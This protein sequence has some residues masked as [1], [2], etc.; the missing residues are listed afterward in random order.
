MP[1]HTNRMDATLEGDR[2]AER[3][4]TPRRPTDAELSG[5]S[6]M[7]LLSWFART[8][9]DPAEFRLQASFV[10]FDA[11]AM[12]RLRPSR[13]VLD[14]TTENITAVS[15]GSVFYVVCSGSVVFS[16]HG[17]D[18]TLGEGAS[19]LV[20][21]TAAHQ[22]RI[23]DGAELLLVVVRKG[24]LHGRGV[25]EPTELRPIPDTAFATAVSL[26]LRTLASDLPLPSSAEGIASQSAIVQ[27]LT[28]LIMEIA[29]MPAS[30]AQHV[31]WIASAVTFIAGNYSNPNLTT[32]AVAAATGISSRHLQRIFALA[33]TSVA[34]E[35]RRTRTRW[36]VTWIEESAGSRKLEEIAILAG[37]GTVA[38]MRRAFRRQVGMSPL[39]YRAAAARGDAPE[40]AGAGA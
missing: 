34:D 27:L 1:S 39:Q 11:L 3:I 9:A 40:P 21:G 17:K 13:S 6:G 16:Q 31:A 38:R 14:R 7:D 36:A 35:L 18:T 12:F 37:F 15:L 19:A 8:V 5:K 29:E 4:F 30:S 28:G 22:L 10:V 24:V 23:A 26:F 32:A 20:S 25:A 2:A 33:D